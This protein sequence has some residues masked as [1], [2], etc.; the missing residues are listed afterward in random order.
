MASRETDRERTNILKERQSYRIDRKG[1]S[2][3]EQTDI[4]EVIL[5]EC[6]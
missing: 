5:V 3:T 6:L 1:D 2:G 4:A